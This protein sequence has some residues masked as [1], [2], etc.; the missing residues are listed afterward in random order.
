MNFNRNIATILFHLF[1]Y[2]KFQNINMKHF[3]ERILFKLL[4][5]SFYYKLNKNYM[6]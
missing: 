2:H 4:S 1:L 3:E 5:L 6:I